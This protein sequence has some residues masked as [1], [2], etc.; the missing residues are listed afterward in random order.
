MIELLRKRRSIRRY[1]EKKISKKS[2]EIVIESLLRAPSSRDF[3]PCEFILVDDTALLSKLSEAKE[4]G[5]Q[6]LRKAQLSIVIC[7]DG[8]KSDVWV[9]DCSIASILVQMTALSLGLG[10][11]WIQIR[12]RKHDA[13]E[14]SE[15]YV[16][17]ILG[18]PGHIRVEA[19]ISIGYPGEAKAPVAEDKLD[20]SKVRLNHY[21]VQY[22]PGKNNM[23]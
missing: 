12:K 19:M 20:Y 5:S 14:T 18:L 4:H 23:A 21:S 7:A 15:R 17:K 11:C 1:T 9:E 16:Q 2:V 8:R 6:F 22:T 3:K 10:S 13:K